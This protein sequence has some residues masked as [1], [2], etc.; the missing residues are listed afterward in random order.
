MT[1]IEILMEIKNKGCENE[2]L[3]ALIKDRIH[4]INELESTNMSF[5]ASISAIKKINQ[6]RDEFIDALCEKEE[7]PKRK[8]YYIQMEI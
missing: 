2:I 6:S 1:T 3:L 5:N 7:V 8:Q 4:H